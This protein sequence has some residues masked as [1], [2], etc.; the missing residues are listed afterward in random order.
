MSLIFYFYY[1]FLYYSLSEE[2]DPLSL[3]QIIHMHIGN[4]PF[5]SLYELPARGYIFFMACVFI[6]WYR[7]GFPPY[8]NGIVQD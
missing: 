4:G 7:H 5:R 3:P 2:K 1:G 8:N 6:D